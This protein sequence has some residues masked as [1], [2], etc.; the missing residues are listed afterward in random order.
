MAERRYLAATEVRALGGSSPEDPLRI[1]GYASVFNQRA[2]LPGFQERMLPGA[3]TRAVNQNQDVVCLFNHNEAFLLGRTTSKTLRLKQDTRGL[4]FVCDLPNTQYA[5]DLHEQIQRGD[6]NGCSFGFGVNGADG[7]V[8]TEEREA[9]GTYFIQRDVS[10]VNLFDVSPVVHPAYDGTCVSARSEAQPPAEL[11]SAVDAKNAALVVPPI[12]KRDEDSPVD[13][14][15]DNNAMSFEDVKSA[16]CAALLEKFGCA[17]N[18]S[19][20]KWSIAETFQDYVV[21]YDCGDHMSLGP[22]GEGCNY[23]KVSYTL[24][25]TGNIVLGDFVPVVISQEFVIDDGMRAL[26]T[27]E[28][29]LRK[30]GVADEGDDEEFED[31]LE[32]RGTP[33]EF[34]DGH[35]DGGDCADGMCGCQNRF[36]FDKRADGTQGEIRSGSTRTKHVGGKDL[37]VSAFKTVGDPTKTETWKG[38]KA[39]ALSKMQPTEPIRTAILTKE[40]RDAMFTDFATRGCL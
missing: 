34:S 14:V 12:E 5:R 37:P 27:K 16:I 29:E 23:G 19:W 11:R 13:V 1:E 15:L 18:T 20:A 26:I 17:P 36:G 3:F 30:A 21:V 40:E 25:A 8:W 28:I 35:L 24:D 38:V 22:L 6:I 4:H 39:G 7:Q 31:E 10:D 32:D 2:K 33:A 9:D